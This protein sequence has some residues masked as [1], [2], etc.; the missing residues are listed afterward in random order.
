[1]T[2][3]TFSFI[4]GSR[5]GPR[6]AEWIVTA[7]GRDT[8]ITTAK[9]RKQ[10]KATLHESGRWHI[11]DLAKP[12]DSPFI[13]TH[14]NTV[15]QGIE[16][17]GLLIVIPDQC[18]RPA[19]L[20]DTMPEPFC[21]LPRPPYGGLTEVAVADFNFGTSNQSPSGVKWPG[22]DH[23]TELVAICRTHHGRAIALVVRQFSG[24]HPIAKNY[25]KVFEGLSLPQPIILNSPER[26]GVLFGR[27]NLGSLL[28][29]EFAVD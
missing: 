29:W 26:R 24:D 11:K 2:T 8:Y 10:W 13:K 5:F 6:S 27:S 9:D 14:R 1:M 3:V 23:G 7:A 20:P 4:V 25:M 28:I 17:P 18:L 21:W 19:S 16:A 22:Q 12:G 15:P